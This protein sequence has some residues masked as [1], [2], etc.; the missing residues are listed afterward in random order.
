MSMFRSVA[1]ALFACSLAACQSQRP[2]SGYDLKASTYRAGSGDRCEQYAYESGRTRYEIQ[3][4][5][6]GQAFAAANAN[7]IAQ[8]AYERCASGRLN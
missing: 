7:R 4:M 1:T 8:L 3:R 2:P 5:V 6:R